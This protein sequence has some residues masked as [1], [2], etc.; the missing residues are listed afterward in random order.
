MADWTRHRCQGVPVTWQKPAAPPQGWVVGVAA[1]GDTLAQLAKDA[2]KLAADIAAA[3]G[4]PMPPQPKKPGCQWGRDVAEWV[5]GTG[6][7]R[8]PVVAGQLNACEPGK[9]HVA[10]VEGQRII[11]PPGVRP[12]PFTTTPTTP[13]RAAKVGAGL[14]AGLA[15]AWLAFKKKVPT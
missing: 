4:V 1:K 2:G 10:L 13:K 12:P 9:G 3:N 5:L 8:L 15:L 6:G 11:L 14:F 7:V